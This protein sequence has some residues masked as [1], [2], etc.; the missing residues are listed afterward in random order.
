MTTNTNASSGELQDTVSKALRCAWHLGQTYWQQADS[1][2]TSQHRRS[3]ETQAKFDA[4]VEEMRAVFAAAQPHVQIPPENVHVDCDVSRKAEK[5]D[6]SAAPKAAKADP[7]P[8]IVAR[9]E[10]ALRRIEDGHSI[11]RIPADPTDPDLVLAECKAFF[12]GCPP[13]FWVK[14]EPAHK[15]QTND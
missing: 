4:L 13:P 14:A 7:A 9:L 5:V 3:D 10:A 15:E 6:T 12:E 2:Y 8:G 11:R 1:E